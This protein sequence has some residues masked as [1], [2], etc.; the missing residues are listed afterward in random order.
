MLTKTLFFALWAAAVTAFAPVYSASSTAR[1]AIA[2]TQLCAANERTYIMVSVSICIS[3][4][5]FGCSY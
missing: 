3:D 4:C 2:K 1:S 5:D